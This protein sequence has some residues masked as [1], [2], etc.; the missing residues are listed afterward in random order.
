MRTLPTG[1]SSSIPASTRKVAPVDSSTEQANTEFSR[2]HSTRIQPSV[3]TNRH[4][5]GPQTVINTVTFQ[6]IASLSAPPPASIQED[7]L[8]LAINENVEFS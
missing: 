8:L 6:P 1:V 4:E 5:Y 2:L 7:E 3:L